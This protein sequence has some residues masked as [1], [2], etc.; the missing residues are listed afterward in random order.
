MGQHFFLGPSEI[1]SG[2]LRYLLLF[3]RHLP[4]FGVNE[5]E[6]A[7]FLQGGL[8]EIDDSEA[9]ELLLRQRNQLD[10]NQH[11]GLIFRESNH[12]PGV[13]EY[14]NFSFANEYGLFKIGV[15]IV[16]FVQSHGWHLEM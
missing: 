5:N 6:K 2:W 8:V 11:A 10:G 3:L 14:L 1:E 7:V 4:N 15:F 12:L 13:C 9:K 16:A